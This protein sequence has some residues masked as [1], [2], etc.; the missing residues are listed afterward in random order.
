M[1]QS[2]NN[3]APGFKLLVILVFLIVIGIFV[4]VMWY[5]SVSKRANTA[6]LDIVHN[7]S[8]NN[9]GLEWKHIDISGFPFRIEIKLHDIDITYL[10]Y[11]FN[12]RNT[13]V[14]HHPWN[15]NHILIISDKIL[16]G[17][18]D[19]YTNYNEG[20]LSKYKFNYIL[21]ENAKA[22][23]SKKNNNIRISIQIEEAV[24]KLYEELKGMEHVN[25][26]RLETSEIHF[27]NQSNAS[28]AKLAIK[29]N[30]LIFPEKSFLNDPINFITLEGNIID[31]KKIK[32]NNFNEWLQTDGGL[33]IEKLFLNMNKTI[34]RGN[35]FLGIDKNYNLIG[36]FVLNYSGLSRI[37]EN[38]YE[39]SIISK[40]TS[41]ALSIAA[42][43]TEALAE[44][45]NKSP[46]VNLMLQ[47]GFLYM[48]GIQIIKIADVKN[49]FDL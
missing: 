24:F 34:I 38:L 42:D 48:F 25:A 1:K 43:A 49:F 13:R 4:Y 44:F 47:D 11:I 46:E 22:S 21:I 10:N 26:Y 36:T 35:G 7:L 27:L 41:K 23:Y 2:K 31:I 20:N 5:N 30:N 19:N 29:I 40:T 14:V 39:K 32:L 6:L 17:T 18:Q 33:D 15:P 9:I 3:Y 45:N 37:F 12:L 28:D 16:L 8:S